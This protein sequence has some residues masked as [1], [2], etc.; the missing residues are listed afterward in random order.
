MSQRTSAAEPPGADLPPEPAPPTEPAPAPGPAPTSLR[1]RTRAAAAS[2]H[3]WLAVAG[4]LLG[5]LA[6]LLLPGLLPS[7]YRA[8]ASLLIH[9]LDGNPYSPTTQGSDLVNLETEAQVARSDAVVAAVAQQLPGSTGRSGL[10][11]GLSVSVVPNTQVLELT[12]SA[13]DADRAGEVAAL[14]AASYLEHRS[15]Q[16]D[17]R[18]DSERS[19]LEERIQELTGQ[20]DELRATDAGNQD[21]E[22]RAIGGQLL[23]LRLQSAALSAAA[24]SPGRVI[25][26]PAARASGLPVPTW[27]GGAAG[28]LLGL[29][30]GLGLG[31]L[32]EQRAGLVRTVEDVEA[33]GLVVVA[34]HRGHAAEAG[35]SGT[36]GPS[37][38]ARAAANLVSRRAEPP[39]TI[40][41]AALGG[42]D[43]ARRLSLELADVL[44]QDSESTL[45]IDGRRG[46]GPVRDGLSEI[47]LRSRSLAAV[48][49]PGGEEVSYLGAG[50][51]PDAAA[52][53]YASSR[54]T[55]LL[56]D[57]AASYSWV[58]VDCPAG[59]TTDGRSMVS[60]CRYWIP[61]V[62]P[63]R[64][65]R[66]DVTRAL[67]W[68]ES[69]GVTVLGCVI[70][71]ADRPGPRRPAVERAEAS[72]PGHG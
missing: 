3:P 67:V 12:F 47:L 34:D 35:P 1:R 43:G 7:G 13:E 53:L 19:R 64:T 36:A 70:V 57:A 40:A 69:A 71:D 51:D 66:H 11:S 48:V 54:M 22:V 16:R 62:V 23:N 42:T 18:L 61:V 21:P 50:R 37:E 20:L 68:A 32:R 65:T 58:V 52:R 33:L 4:L 9:P 25:T 24:T 45:L 26:A 49:A 41:V 5:L 56:D 38:A 29:L 63:G 60:A 2:W 46:N 6:G 10:E 27:L 14:F 44:S 31:R 30:A 39:R 28:G 8:T 15:A 72:E 55:R 59:T 17:T